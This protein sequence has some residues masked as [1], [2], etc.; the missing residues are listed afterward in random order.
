MQCYENFINM[1]NNRIFPS[2]MCNLVIP[3]KIIIFKKNTP[4][5]AVPYVEHYQCNGSHN[6]YT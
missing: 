4:S 3:Y 1:V 6:P 5:V 2:F